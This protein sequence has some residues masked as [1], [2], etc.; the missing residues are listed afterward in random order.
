[1]AILIVDDSPDMRFLLRSILTKA[2]YNQILDAE[3]A[4]AAFTTLNL[5]GSQSLIKVDLILMDARMPGIDGIE[6]C[7]R[8]KKQI[9]LRDIPIIMVTANHN[10]DNLKEAFSAGVMDYM[11]KPF[12]TVELLARIASAMTLKAIGL[13]KS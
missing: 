12:N 4:Q 3:S 7:R 13:P 8:I 5:C 6:A 1:M 10:L 2:G 9:H 11:T